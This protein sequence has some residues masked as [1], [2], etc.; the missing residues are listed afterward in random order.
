MQYLQNWAVGFT[1]WNLLLDSTGGP[2]HDRR[3]GCNAP[4]MSDVAS[5][6]G[7]VV[8]APYY[9]LRHFARYL[10]PHTRIV[11]A[12]SYTGNDPPAPRGSFFYDKGA[13]HANGDGL[14]VLGGIHANGTRVLVVMNSGD[15]LVHYKLKDGES[16][17]PMSIPGHAIQTLRWNPLSKVHD[18]R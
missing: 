12:M 2:S 13:E 7:V 17:A 9:F 10:R 4:L 15:A 18:W 11:G 8:Q 5:P 6:A 1:D 3:F 14:A 16:S